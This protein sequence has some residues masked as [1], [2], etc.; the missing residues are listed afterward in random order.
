MRVEARRFFAV[1]RA[2]GRNADLAVMD[3]H[4]PEPSTQTD[5]HLGGRSFRTDPD[6]FSNAH[7][8]GQ[9]WAQS[10]KKR[11]VGMRSGATMRDAG[12]A[13]MHGTS[14]A[15]KRLRGPR[16]GTPIAWADE[17]GKSDNIDRNPTWGVRRSSVERRK[18]RL[19]PRAG[20]GSGPHG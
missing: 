2:A 9:W 19:R 8:G 13:L 4:L 15:C 17:K 6:T 7:R 5:A 20:P 18:G 3:V 11:L 16:P 12:Q 10:R 1:D 14:E